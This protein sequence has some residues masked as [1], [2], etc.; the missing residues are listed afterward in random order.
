ME[1]TLSHDVME[2]VAVGVFTTADITLATTLMTSD[3]PG[4]R[5]YEVTIEDPWPKDRNPR[6]NFHLAVDDE[7]MVVDALQRFAANEPRG[8]PISNSGEYDEH[9]RTLVLAMRRVRAAANRKRQ[10]T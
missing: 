3:Y 8:L 5:L 7:L 2:Q 4:I 1:H 6:C 10:G 9:K